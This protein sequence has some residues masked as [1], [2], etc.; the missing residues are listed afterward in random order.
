MGKEIG[1][2]Q[3]QDAERKCRVKNTNNNNFDGFA[4]RTY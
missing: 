4:E 2:Y 1:G 3:V